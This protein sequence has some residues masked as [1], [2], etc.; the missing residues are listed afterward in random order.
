M[1]MFTCSVLELLLQV[2][3]KKFT[4][5]FVVTRL[6]P[7]RFTHRDMKPAAFLLSIER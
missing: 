5:D 1:V 2:L 7:Q 4:W 6:N 3:L